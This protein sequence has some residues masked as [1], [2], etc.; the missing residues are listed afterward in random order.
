MPVQ[1]LLQDCRLPALDFMSLT[2]KLV[3]TFLLVTLIPIGVIIWVSRQT[4]VEQAQQ[5]IGT[6]LEDSVVQ[7]GKSM[8]EF[9]FNSIHHV[10]AM[11]ADPELG[12]GDLNVAN[13]DLARL[14]DAFSYFDQVMLVNPQGVI[15]AASDSSSY[16]GESLFTHF[17]NTRD[18]F[19]LALRSRPGS[20]YISD[21]GEGL[22]SVSQMAPGDRPSNRFLE[23]QILVSVQDSEG[24][25]V[26]VIVANVLT[27]QLLGLLQDL[28]RQAPGDEF[29]CLLDKA[30]LVLMSADP[31]A[32]LLSVHVDATS[33]ALRAALGSVNNGHLV[34]TDSRGHKLMAGYTRLATYGDNSAG[35]WRLISVASYQTIMKPADESFNRMMGLLLATLL[36]AGVLGVLVSRRQV[37]PLLKLTEGA[38]TIAAGKYDA[39]V[40]ATTHDEIGILANTFNQMADA[41]EA[42]ASERTQAQEALFRANNELEQRVDERTSQLV[43]EIRERKGAEQT[44]RESEAELNAYFERSPVGMVLVDR[45]LRYLKA[46]QRLAEMTKVSLDLLIGKTVR[47]IEP[48]LADILEPL[49]Q[50][51]FASGKPILNFELSR[52]PNDSPGER[53]D[54][55]LFFFPVMG[56]DV[57]PKAVG[58][59]T[60]DI[61][62]LKRAEVKANYAKIAAESA[63]QAK[64]EFLANMSH[65]IRTPMNGVIGITELLLETDLTV[66]Q[67]DFAHTIRSSGEALLAVINDILDFSKM[68]AGQLA[69]EE[70]DFNLHSVFEGTL[71]LLASRC[72]EKEIEL[73]GLIEC[74]VPRQLRGDAGRIRQVLTNLVGNAIKFT[75]VGEVTVRVSCDVEREQDCD[76]RF[77]VSDTGLGISP[78]TQKKLFKAFS[79]A[80]SSTTRKFGGTGL[81]LAISRQLVEK[82]GG[83]IGVESA[84][85]KGSTFWFTTRLRKSPPRLSTLDLNHRLINIRALVVDDH[86]VSGQFIH[87]QIAAWKMRSDLA[88]TGAE[89]LSRLYSAA[90]ERDPYQLAIIDQQVPDMDGMALAQKIK[91]APTV[92]ET[93][94]ILLAG[95]G[96]RV[97]SEELRASGFTDCCSK[98]VRQSALFDC[99]AN[100]VNEAS[101]PLPPSPA[102][103]QQPSSLIPGRQKARVLVAEDNPVN[104][105]VALGQLK[106]LGYMAEIACNGR[107]VLDALERTHYDIILMDCQMPEIDGYEATRRIRTRNDGFPQPY[108]IAMTA[109]AMTGDSEKCLE[110]GMNDHVSKPVVLQKLAAALARGTEVAT[111]GRN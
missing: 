36:V 26:G 18:K 73:A 68:E 89:A 54:Y 58:V 20:V 85:G 57:R 38:K 83:E 50:E 22:K 11:A 7:V 107:A 56:D 41:L 23:I 80:D 21:L 110:A 34:Y 32:R 71:E 111:K 4:L 100:A 15:I 79:Q 94:L 43:A 96:K 9:M 65:D 84:L 30:G 19:Q 99:L 108:I 67:R 63:N 51:V 39:R 77:K 6:R 14:A 37:K 48:S 76:L 52:E 17:S 90:R 61:T 95:F 93:R 75:E 101:A 12:S 1:K 10:Q 53:R 97:S 86:A 103:Q 64:S 104:Q 55:Q 45:Q 98:P 28:K 47:E 46:N 44:A 88:T 27:R 5:Q 78:E 72:Q 59:V 92:S 60:L 16:L 31:R 70:I 35:D 82:M 69:I 25:P 2:K 109:H 29:P 105:M 49:Y 24:R 40:V 91:T 81:G 102:E 74:S 106:Q 33:G 62:E 87:E 3:L 8:D 13:R 66:E 42:R